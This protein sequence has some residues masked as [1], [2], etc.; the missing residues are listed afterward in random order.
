MSRGTTRLSHNVI[1]ALY[2][3]LDWYNNNRSVS[4]S[5]RV[6]RFYS[7]WKELH[8]L[9]INI[10]KEGWDA[11]ENIAGILSIQ[12]TNTERRWLFLYSIETYLNIFIRSIALSKLGSAK[13]NINDFYKEIN[14]R[15]GIFEPNVFEWIF[16]AVQDNNL[17]PNLRR[18]LIE[19]LNTMLEVIY[20]LDL[21]HVTFDIFREIYQNILPREIRRSLGEFYTREDIVREVLQSANLDSNAVIKLYNEWNKGRKSGIYILD[22][23]C[24]SG[25]FLIETI[26]LIF[27]SFTDWIPSDICNFITDIIVGI[28]INPFAVEMAKLNVILTIMR[29]SSKRGFGCIPN[30]VKIY[31]ADS[32]ARIKNSEKLYYKVLTINIP[33]LTQII[34]KESISIPMCPDASFKEILDKTWEAV[35]SGTNRDAFISDIV[36][37]FCASVPRDAIIKDIAELY[38]T[39]KKIHE[40]GNS[41]ILNLLMNTITVQSLVNSCA[42]VIGNPPWVRIRELSPY[43]RNY[44]RNNYSWLQRGSAYNPNFKRTKVPFREQF[45][46]SVA[47]LERGLEFLSDGGILSYV[48]TSKI[49]RTLYAGKMREDLLTKYTIIRIIDYSLHRVPLFQDVVNYPLVISVQKSKPS[50]SSHTVNITVYNTGG[51]PKNF[52]L[53]QNELPLDLNDKQSPW[54]LAPPPVSKIVRTLYQK[55]IRL[56]DVYEV[57]MGVKTSLN[58]IYIGNLVNCNAKNNIAR[59]ELKINNQ[60]QYI[61]VEEF[62][63]H[64]V[65]RGEDIDPFKFAGTEYIIFPHDTANF[66]PLWDNDQKIILQTLGL[67][68]SG[69]SV[70]ASGGIVKYVKECEDNC[71]KC[72]NNANNV[73]Q[74]LSN[75]GFNITKLS[76]QTYRILK[77]NQLILEIGIEA[78][79]KHNTCTIE[80]N[81]IGL[82]IPNAPKATAHFRNYFKNLVKRDDYRNN[83]SP[84]AIFRVSG[85]KFREYRIAWQE[86]SRHLETAYLPVKI[87]DNKCNKDKVLIPIQTVYFIVE[88]NIIKALKLLL[89]LNS[90]LARNLIKLWAWSARGGTYRHTSYTVGHLPIPLPLIECNMWNL[91][92]NYID[93]NKSADKALDLNSIGN[94]ILNKHKDELA[95][96]LLEVLNIN[97]D[98]YELLVE[99]GEWLNEI[100][101]IEEEGIEEEEIE[102][103]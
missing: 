100:A 5:Q 66:E 98:D 85:D 61:D 73:I 63:V 102:E 8:A 96:E 88:E 50:S 40:S 84:W 77:N 30:E 93:K 51:Q 94:E 35:I 9:S 56:G 54:I 18:Q 1:K 47:F 92:N 31:W 60:S 83:L 12:L 13:Q 3:V 43:V 86:M 44:L 46:Y 71:N 64:P 32:L 91:I 17:D 7:I 103:E 34:G 81:I 59:L 70:D 24:G 58:D 29:E 55:S 4:N 21:T 48:I 45:D 28:D 78:A 89:Y 67:L 101:P 37:R 16:D 79:S 99:Y 20:N 62:L 33:A 25:T 97:K 53:N 76:N 57:M 36:E 14:N 52:T 80:F 23:A 69:V 2:Q 10:S 82:K 22:P 42:Y 95:N 49:I 38:D 19:S 11:L 75:L 39:M 26:K 65:V 41:R 74:S 27:N 87:W 72:L 15:R 6:L 90:D 68:G